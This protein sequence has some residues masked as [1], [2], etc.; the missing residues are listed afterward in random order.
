MFH[1]L[2]ARKSF[3]NIVTIKNDT[4]LS[5]PLK[6]IKNQ[7]TETCVARGNNRRVGS[8]IGKQRINHLSCTTDI[9]N[10]RVGSYAIPTRN[11]LNPTCPSG[12]WAAQNLL[13]QVGLV[14]SLT[15]IAWIVST[16]D[17]KIARNLYPQHG[18]IISLEKGEMPLVIF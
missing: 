18:P 17:N 1:S 11:K 15:F 2:Q 14:S 8:N 5:S 13:G 16:L 4:G 6:M 7:W 9:G 10:C 3:Y 12:W